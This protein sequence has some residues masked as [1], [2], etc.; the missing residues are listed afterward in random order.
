MNSIKLQDHNYFT[1]DILKVLAQNRIT[2]ILEFI[3]EDA[4]KLSVLT[5]L[6]LAK[7]LEIRNEIFSQ[8][9]AP[10]ISGS[11]LLARSLSCKKYVTTGISR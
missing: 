2:T 1:S 7:V 3:Q 4:E 8:Y 9:S 10:L 5:K 11:T 6:N